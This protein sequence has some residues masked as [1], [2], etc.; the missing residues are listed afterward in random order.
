[1]MNITPPTTPHGDERT[2][3]TQM[4][5]YLFR[6]SEQLNTIQTTLDAQAAKA[7]ERIAQAAKIDTKELKDTDNQYT[8]LVSL[9]V[10]TANIVQSRMDK[11]VTRL[12]SEYVAQ[13]EWGEYRVAVTR[14]IEE[15]AKYTLEN[16]RYGAEVLNI[17][18]MA[19]DFESYRIETE[20]FIRRG[21][22]GYDDDGYPILGIAIAQELKGKTVTI[23][24]TEYEEFDRTVNMATYTAEK[25]SFWINGV[26]MAYLSNGELYV[27]RIIVLD[28]IRLG[29][30]NIDVNGK[31]EL[32]IQ[33]EFSRAIVTAEAVNVI[34]A[35]INLSANGSITDIN[36]DVMMLSTQLEQTAETFELQINRKVDGEELQEYLRYDAGTVEIGSSDSRYRL[37]ADSSG[38]TILRDGEAMTLM[39]QNAV[40]APVFETGRKLKIGGYSIKLSAN[41]TLIFN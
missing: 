26:E 17:P 27:T 32:E 38:V 15:T 8:A 37:Q 7:S 34:A 14:E 39:K 35:E 21:I 23:D 19:A 22:I 10:K 31:D 1:M 4:Y 29:G 28:S 36:G 33:K 12:K 41:G 24:G 2:A 5:S 9:V 11:I 16:Y 30:W 25:L 6:L 3:I 13:S 18:E 20:G 40:S